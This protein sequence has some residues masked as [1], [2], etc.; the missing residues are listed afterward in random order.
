MIPLKFFAVDEVSCQINQ[1]GA[2]KDVVEKV[3]FV[4]NNVTLA[5][6]NN[7]VDE[8]KKFDTK[9]F[10]LVFHIFSYAKG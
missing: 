1:E 6:L 10:F 7:K 4:L 8:L 3:L 5:N 9:L 2:P